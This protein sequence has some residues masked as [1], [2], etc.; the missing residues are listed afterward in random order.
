MVQDIGIATFLILLWK[1]MYPKCLLTNSSEDLNP[2]LEPWRDWG[3]PPGGF[4]DLGYEV[5]ARPCCIQ[6][7]TLLQM[8]QWA[9]NSHSGVGRIRRTRY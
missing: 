6:I 2:S 1:Q 5:F 9:V 4:L 3:R 8:R 7:D